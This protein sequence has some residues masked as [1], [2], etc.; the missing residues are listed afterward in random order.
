MKLASRV[1]L[2]TVV[3][4]LGLPGIAQQQSGHSVPAPMPEFQLL[5]LDGST[6]D[7]QKLPALKKWLLIYVR[8]NCPSCDKVLKLVQQDQY[9]GLPSMMAV[10]VGG[11]TPDKVQN[12]M[13]N[14][15][16]LAGA[17][18]Y[19]DPQKAASD[20][21]KLSGT[22]AIIGVR[23]STLAWHMMGMI[24]PDPQKM[25]SLLSSWCK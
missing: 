15:P 23:G 17:S 16:N 25:T 7:S 24:F 19:A 20:A 12:M 22:P 4:L 2:L 10:V 21:L 3:G 13:K 11:V 5:G 9:P 18:W 8:P 14:Y 1:L 6:V